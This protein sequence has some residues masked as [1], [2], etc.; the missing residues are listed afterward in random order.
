MAICASVEKLLHEA[1]DVPRERVYPV[2]K[3]V[4]TFHFLLHSGTKS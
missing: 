4:W 1:T 2:A 3:I